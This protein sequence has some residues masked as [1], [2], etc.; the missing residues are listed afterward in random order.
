MK[1]SSI[2][3]SFGKKTICYYKLRY[4]IFNIM[5]DKIGKSQEKGLPYNI[6][7]TYK[8]LSEYFFHNNFTLLYILYTHFL[9]R[10]MT[11]IFLKYNIHKFTTDFS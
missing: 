4:Y 9:I 11:S 6:L 5:E 7:K 10:M 8:I 2:K 3:S 1:L